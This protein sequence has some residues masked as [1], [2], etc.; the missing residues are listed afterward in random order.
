MQR[1]GWRRRSAALQFAVT[2]EGAGVLSNGS[3]EGPLL[4][5]RANGRIQRYVCHKLTV[6][7]EFQ[8]VPL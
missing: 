5:N 6:N 7:L 4:Q 8:P 3:A 1:K 2:Q